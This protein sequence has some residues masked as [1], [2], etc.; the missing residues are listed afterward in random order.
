MFEQTLE[1]MVGSV[2]LEKADV[3]VLDQAGVAIFAPGI[4]RLSYVEAAE[5][6]EKMKRQAVVVPKRMIPRYRACMNSIR[7][8]FGPEFWDRH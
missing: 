3:S 6:V 7:T 5:L 1:E 4:L 2:Y 8:S